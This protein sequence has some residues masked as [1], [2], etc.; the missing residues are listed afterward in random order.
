MASYYTMDCGHQTL[1]DA[2]GNQP[3]ETL[4]G[5]CKD[6]KAARIGDQIDFI[7]FGA[8]PV[9]SF[10]HRDGVAEEGVSV[11]EIKNGKADLVGWYF[12]FTNRPA[13]RGKGVIVGWGSDGEPLVKIMK[14]K[15]LSPKQKGA[16]L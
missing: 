2:W 12:G 1:R 4:A 16:I 15:K 3:A 14:I 6:C 7:R 13:Y 11:Y 10:N 8:A 5:L 9:V